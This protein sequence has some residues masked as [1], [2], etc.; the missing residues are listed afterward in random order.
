M[1]HQVS[2]G[3]QMNGSRKNNPYPG[4]L[5]SKRFAAWRVHIHIGSWGMKCLGNF[6]SLEDAIQA[7]KDAEAKYYP[8]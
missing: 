3:P 4:V 1:K 7:R 5:W 2:K 8:N 6:E